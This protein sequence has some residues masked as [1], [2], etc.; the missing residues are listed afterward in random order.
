M[1][2]GAGTGN[3]PLGPWGISREPSARGAIRN[4]AGR[5]EGHGDGCGSGGLQRGAASRSGPHAP[6][7]TVMM[8]RSHRVDP[9]DRQGAI[10]RSPLPST[11]ATPPAQDLSPQP[12][13]PCRPCRGLGPGARS[14][15]LMEPT[16]TAWPP[17][18]GAA[19]RARPGSHISYDTVLHYHTTLELS[20]SLAQ[21][22]SP[23]LCF[24][25]PRC[26]SRSFSLLSLPLSGSLTFSL[27][28]ACARANRLLFIC[29]VQALGNGRDQATLP[30]Q[31]AVVRGGIG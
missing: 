26:V 11:S 22:F 8:S 5:T 18:R 13:P 2:P 30:R 24:S 31:R 7:L 27:T 19:C 28:L 10:G 1:R 4:A 15:S 3:T 23:P 21:L 20:L 14:G 12:C 29:W 25:L 6:A 9:W 17:R 16:S